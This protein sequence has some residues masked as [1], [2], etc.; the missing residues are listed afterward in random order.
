MRRNTKP[1]PQPA[2]TAVDDPA[3]PV[4]S[5][6]SLL[7]HNALYRRRQ[8]LKTDMR[9][10]PLSIGLSARPW[11]DDDTSRRF[12]VSAGIW[13]LRLDMPGSLVESLVAGLCKPAIFHTLSSL[14]QA[15]LIEAA[16][17]NL[18]SPFE[19]ALLQP[20]Q[21]VADA[22]LH[23]A[24]V[25]LDLDVAFS[26]FEGVVRVG[27]NTEA[28][29]LIVKAWDA[30]PAGAPFNVNGLPIPVQLLAGAQTLSVAEIA[31][32][33]PGD[34]IMSESS[35]PGELCA[36]CA[37]QLQ[38]RCIQSGQGILLTSN[39]SPATIT[40]MDTDEIPVERGTAMDEGAIDNLPVRVIFELARTDLSLREVKE[41][42]EGS[43]VPV[44]AISEGAV[45]IIANGRKIGQGDIV[46]LGEG[47]GVR[48][49]QLGTHD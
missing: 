22:N 28:S 36:L 48:I 31:A 49:L 5:P 20:L 46:R 44:A 35:V 33:Q 18:L 25:K 7:A 13:N 26:T 4:I 30:I 16:L 12:T 27:L 2:Y 38:A 29:K 11:A 32:L 17:E 19:T 10:K 37:G 1:S 21:F 47:L 23:H 41:L 43:I 15:I 9:G 8:T 42:A 39:W 6:A 3:F 14:Q 24:D 45:A 34:T 40:R